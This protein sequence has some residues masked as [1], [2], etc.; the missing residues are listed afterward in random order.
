MEW[1]HDCCHVLLHVRDDVSFFFSSVC[2]FSTSMVFQYM[3]QFFHMVLFIFYHLVH[4]A[5]TV[6][7]RSVGRVRHWGV[8]TSAPAAGSMVRKDVFVNEPQPPK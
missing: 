1:L 8:P 3:F 4:G 2:F 7:N 5:S 6:L